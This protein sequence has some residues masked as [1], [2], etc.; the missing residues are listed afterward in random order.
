MT[1]DDTGGNHQRLLAFGA[2]NALEWLRPQLAWEQA[3][4]MA[5]HMAVDEPQLEHILTSQRMLKPSTEKR[6]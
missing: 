5:I 6:V 3:Q 2:D 1:C 4:Q